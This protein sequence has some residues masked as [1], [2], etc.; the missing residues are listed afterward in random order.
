MNKILIAPQTFKG[1]LNAFEAAQAMN[2]G[3]KK[4]W[5]EAVTIVSPL[6]DG[7]DGMLDILLKAKGGL[8]KTAFAANALGKRVKTN[9]GI[10]LQSQT[11]IIELAQICGLASLPASQRNPLTTT[12]YGVGEVIK[13]A[14]DEGIT[15]F[16]IG[17][18]GSA[19]ND[20]GAGIAQAL[21]ARLMD[22]QGNDLH[23]GGEYLVKLDRIDLSGMDPR[24]KNCRFKVA[25]DVNSPLTGSLGASLTYSPQKG[26]SPEAAKALEAALTHYAEVLEEKLGRS[27]DK[28]PGSWGCWRGCSRFGCLPGSRTFVRSRFVDGHVEY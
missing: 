7:G 10:F 9:W 5:P 18:G 15:D 1:T 26:A 13:T 24:L 25:C 2:A 3:V 14:L 12:T 11:A 22:A 20:G 16:L 4:A 6:S 28:I 21:G 27:F 8:P 19:T 23:F 17:V